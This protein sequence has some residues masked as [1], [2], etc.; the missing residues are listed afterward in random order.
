MNSSPNKYFQK[1][2]LQ[3]LF[4]ADQGRSWSGC[5][6]SFLRTSH[7]TTKW[8]WNTVK[9]RLAMNFRW[10]WL[11]SAWNPAVLLLMNTAELGGELTSCNSW[12]SVVYFISTGLRGVTHRQGQISFCAMDLNMLHGID[13]HI[14]DFIPEFLFPVNTPIRVLIW[15][16]SD[17]Y[18]QMTFFLP[19]KTKQISVKHP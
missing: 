1:Y 3:F 9:Y 8:Q 17:R 7:W 15:K 5:T 13:R 10:Y 18:K 16:N 12:V 6:A 2:N 11:T 14:D 4:P 19:R